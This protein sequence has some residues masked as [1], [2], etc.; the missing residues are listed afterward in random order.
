VQLEEEKKEDYAPANLSAITFAL[1]LL[2]SLFL[3]IISVRRIR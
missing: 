3:L 1:H 2:A